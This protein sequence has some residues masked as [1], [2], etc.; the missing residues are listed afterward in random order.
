MHEAP[1]RY[2]ECFGTL[3]SILQSMRHC[4]L[5]PPRLTG[6]SDSVPMSDTRRRAISRAW[7]RA[8]QLAGVLL[9]E[10]S[11]AMALRRAHAQPPAGPPLRGMQTQP[12]PHGEERANGHA[13]N[14]PDP[15][16]IAET[17]HDVERAL[18]QVSAAPGAAHAPKEAPQAEEDDGLRRAGPD[19][20]RAARGRGLWVLCSVLL[21]LLVIRIEFWGGPSART[22]QS[23]GS[24]RRAEPSAAR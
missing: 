22:V 13:A 2:E 23:E 24:E 11:G 10:L 15:E 12:P 7:A 17:A 6:L 16:D 1:L 20:G 4:V 3:R 14:G 19:K 5:D 18:K 9:D 8:A 21:L